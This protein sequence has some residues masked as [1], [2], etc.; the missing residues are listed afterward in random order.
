MVLDRKK[1]GSSHL[2]VVGIRVH[3]VACVCIGKFI[4]LRVCITK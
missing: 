4:G 3:E 2:R 1:F